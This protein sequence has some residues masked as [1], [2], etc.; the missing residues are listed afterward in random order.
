M[1]VDQD[2]NTRIVGDPCDRPTA[3]QTQGLPLHSHVIADRKSVPVM[4]SLVR[5]IDGNADVRGL[6]RRERAQLGVQFF[7]LQPRNLLVKVLRQGVDADRVL[8]R[9]AEY[10]NLR[11]GLVRK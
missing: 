3:G 8:A 1:N 5:P 4:L 6:L 9:T 2:E 11:Y 10:L 7:Q